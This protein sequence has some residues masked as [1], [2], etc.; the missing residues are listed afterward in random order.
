MVARS[1][2]AFLPG[3]IDDA[4]HELRAGWGH[5]EK[6][7]ASFRHGQVLL[8][9]LVTLMLR[10]EFAA[11][12]ERTKIEIVPVLG[13]SGSVHSV[14]FSPDGTHVLSGSADEAM[15]LWDAATGTL[16]R[17]FQGH[18]GPVTSVA[19]SHDGARVLSAGREIKL[20]DTMTGEL[21]RT[22]KS[23]G[24]RVAFSPDGARVL[25][26][27][28]TTITLWDAETGALIRT[29]Q[30]HSVGVS[31][32]AFSPDGARV[33]SGGYDGTI[34]L[35]NA[36]TGELIRSV[37]AHLG[38][39]GVWSVAFS[40]NGAR[41]LSGGNDFRIKL[42]DA[43]TGALIRTF[44]RHSLSLSSVA[45]SPDGGR[46]LSGSYDKTIKLWDIAT[47]AL[48]RTFEGHSEGVT[49]VAFSPDGTRVLSGNEDRLN[50]DNALLL[51]DATTGVVIRTFKGHTELVSSVAFSRGG[52]RVL[53]GSFDKTMKL[54]DAATGALIRTFEGH[55]ERVSSVAFSP[56]GARV[57]SGSDDKTIKLWNAAT[58]ALIHTF[59]G[60]S[61]YVS[62][63]AFSPDGARVLSGSWD[64]TVK[65]W[66][67]V[68][69]ALIRTFKGYIRLDG[70]LVP[71]REQPVI[72]VAFSPDGT[73][74]LSGGYERTIK[75][76]DAATGE[77]IRT[78]KGHSDLVSSVAFSP[79]GGAHVLS[80]S[81][82]H[83]IKL[84]DA[85]T[86]TLVRTF[87]GHSEEVTSVAFSPD[88]AHVLSGSSD[89]TIKLWDIATG[90][91]I[92][93][94][95]GHST[96]VSSAAFSPDGGR[97]LSGSW[98]GTIRIWDLSTGQW[99]VSLLAEREGEWLAMTPGGFFDASDG[100]LNM[101]SVVSG[102]KVFSVDQFR[103]QLQRKDL[104][105]ELLSGD[106]L[107]KH[108]DAASKLNLEKIL[109]SG[110]T[111][112]LEL[113]ENEIERGADSIRIKVRIF[114]NEGGGIGKKLVWRVNGQTQGETE[115]DI[116]KNLAGANGP[117]TVTQALKIDSSH[118]NIVTVTAYNGA[119]LL[120]TLPLRYKIDRFGATPVDEQRPRMFILAIGVDGYSE[121]ALTPLKLAVNDV[122]ALA[123]N[124]KASAEA[125][126][127]E[128]GR[129]HCT[130]RIRRHPR[131]Y[132]L[133]L[134]RHCS[135]RKTARRTD[136][137]SSRPRQVGLGALLLH[138]SQHAFR[139][140]QPTEHH[141][142]RYSE[143]NLAAV[144]C[145]RSGRQEAAHNRHLRKLGCRFHHARQQRGACAGDGR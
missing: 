57:L 10:I 115:P 135:A 65:L 144:D 33:L 40:P 39:N 31:S 7:R 14:A 66:D 55:Y 107:R 137:A 45:F 35:W 56:D 54:W 68:T 52:D 124:L 91:L 125:G 67:T 132:C 126:G 9:A 24:Y 104:L 43:A 27:S 62:S 73:R 1:A 59:H 123:D 21:I 34:K 143:R 60:H 101:L 130:A 106:V 22:F 136:R 140:T 50:S 63:V 64:N 81:R 116:L 129:G 83:T 11:A 47:G 30:G 71:L 69:G 84:W 75:L 112:T 76:W 2:A 96:N 29:F 131:E 18:S 145:F 48:I 87:E 100:G 109:D 5:M 111:P 89:A 80:G 127:Y 28:E 138:A 85:A 113:L 99:L 20:W 134:C 72:S 98:D 128:K 37:D 26:S 133:G 42:W 139:R 117:V 120:A 13:H 51:W 82:D 105:Q 36:A 77:L 4:A 110:P 102:F 8:I 88:G 79:D 49:S 16:I 121:P 61:S 142:G 23:S 90:A 95:G 92:R 32:V 25:S 93:T 17:T 70:A 53:S 103:D 86:G 74:V 15:K 3:V 19:F 12:Q 78:F 114:N 97:V 141:H 119:G 44:E 46:V 6:G 122:K 41:V 94:F 58:G 38:G 118:E 108:E